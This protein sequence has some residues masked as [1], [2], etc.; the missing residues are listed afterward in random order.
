MIACAHDTPFLIFSAVFLGNDHFAEG[1][2]QPLGLLQVAHHGYRS[3]VCWIRGLVRVSA[4]LLWSNG[5]NVA[6]DGVTGSSFF[7]VI[8]Q[9]L[10]QTPVIGTFLSL[11][12]IGKVADRLAGVRQSAV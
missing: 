10:R 5:V 3:R 1:A 6:D 2:S 9:A 8:L 7:P 12:I 11:P 4:T